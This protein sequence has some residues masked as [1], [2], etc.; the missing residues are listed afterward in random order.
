[1]FWG[2][3]CANFAKILRTNDELNENWTEFETERPRQKVNWTESELNRAVQK[4]NGTE[5]ELNG[6]V[7]SELNERWTERQFKIQNE[8]ELEL[9]EFQMPTY[10]INRIAPNSKLW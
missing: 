2:C 10:G 7:Q 3:L 4:V 8:T 1:L 5:L 6:P 9:N